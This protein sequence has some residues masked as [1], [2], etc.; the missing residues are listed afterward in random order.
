[1]TYGSFLA[2]SM[3]LEPAALDADIGLFELGVD[4]LAL[5]EAI[6]AVERRWRITLARQAVFAE[7]N[8]AR[9]LVAHVVDAIANRTDAAAGD[10]TSEPIAGRR[11]AT[12]TPPPSPAV[13][14]Q[15]SLSETARTYLD[16][17]ARDYVERSA[18]SRRQRETYEEVLADSRAVAGFR[19]ETK[20]MLYPIVGAKGSGSH[21]VDVDGNDYV[22]LTMG[23]GVQ[24]F[25]HNPVFVV[26]AMQ[27]QLAEQ[28]LFM[29]PQASLAGEVAERIARLTG[30]ERVLFCNTGTEAVMTA[31]RIARHT[32]GRSLV[33]MFAGSYHGHFDGTLARSG[34]DGRGAALAG[35]T[36]P[37]MVEDM[38]VLDYAD[39]EGSL[40][41]LKQVAGN[42]AAVIVEPVQSR[43]PSLQPRHFL[44]QLRAFTDEA[45]AALVFDDVLLGFRVAQGGSQAW[46]DVRADLVTYGKIVGGGLPIGVV[47]RPPRVP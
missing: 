18:E 11:A 44:Q 2:R 30:N 21:I 19:S 39:P 35:G 26:E 29:G 6:A 7:Y 16:G 25:G 20:A 5:T 31:L 33:A 8:N 15:P 42:L 45:G 22:S 38:L 27:R 43:R 13:V 24:L 10:V 34:P 47:A 12:L 46:A 40:E 14:Q 23:F 28:G 3:Q 36:P 17:F 4:S 37:G 32:T 9:R 1:M 41:A